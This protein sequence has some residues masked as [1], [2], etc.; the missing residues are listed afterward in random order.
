MIS[1]WT[2]FVCFPTS[3]SLWTRWTSSSVLWSLITLFLQLKIKNKNKIEKFKKRNDIRRATN[4]KLLSL[5][6]KIQTRKYEL[7]ITIYYYYFV[8]I[9]YLRIWREEDSLQMS[10]WVV[11][12]LNLFLVHSLM[13]QKI[14]FFLILTATWIHYFLCLN[15]AKQ[16]FPAT[17][18]CV[19]F[20]H[21]HNVC[22]CC[23][24]AL[25]LKW[26]RLEAHYSYILEFDYYYY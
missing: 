2:D 19:P 7:Q 4:F 26:K 14:H 5:T 1:T 13:L 12:L 17:T 8:L 20:D 22:M 23:V 24:Y 21:W 10:F 25:V 3:N 11:A 16:N 15:K 9:F 6:K 18:N